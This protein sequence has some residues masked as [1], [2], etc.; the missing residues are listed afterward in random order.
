MYICGLDWIKKLKTLE[1][2]KVPLMRMFPSI[3]QIGKS[4]DREKEGIKKAGNSGKA[5]SL[6]LTLWA[7]SWHC[8][9][10]TVSEDRSF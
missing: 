7:L 4:L 10:H 2:I 3:L 5:V 8:A 9:G 6:E 1:G